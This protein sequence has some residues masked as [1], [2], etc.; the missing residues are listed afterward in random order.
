MAQYGMRFR[1]LAAWMYGGSG[2]G[3]SGLGASTGA[4]V[5]GA[6]ATA[7]AVV[8]GTASAGASD[9]AGASSDPPPPS[10]RAARRSRERFRRCSGISV[11]TSLRGGIPVGHSMH[12]P[13]RTTKPGTGAPGGAGANV[14]E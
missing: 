14:K 12:V 6:G 8:A 4:G 13:E 2:L 10:P 5:A 7:A 9:D 3:G 1:R 11:N